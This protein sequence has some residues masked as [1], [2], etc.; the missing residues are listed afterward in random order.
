M[1][2]CPKACFEEVVV[3]V[4][5]LSTEIADK[6]RL[7]AVAKIGGEL[8]VGQNW[9]IFGGWV[10]SNVGNSRMGLLFSWGLV[11]GFFELLQNGYRR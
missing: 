9:G 1:H 6:V 11:G 4:W 3:E 7:S 8:G 2:M 5:G 10:V